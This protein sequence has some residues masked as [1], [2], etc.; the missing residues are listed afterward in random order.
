M[1]LS[2]DTESLA[3]DRESTVELIRLDISRTF[4]NLCIFQKVRSVLPLFFIYLA[5]YG[6]GVYI[7]QS[8]VSLFFA[9]NIFH[10]FVRN[11]LFVHGLQIDMIA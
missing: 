11:F 9:V 10:S 8:E 5:K 3:A 1:L 6:Y 4:P 7:F 2:S